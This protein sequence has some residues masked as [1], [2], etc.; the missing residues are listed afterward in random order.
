MTNDVN[1]SRELAEESSKARHEG[2][3]E[4]KEAGAGADDAASS[5]ATIM[6]EVQ[7]GVPQVTYIAAG[8]VAYMVFLAIFH[9]SLLTAVP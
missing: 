2:P 1:V 9:P 5:T 6:V 8:F 3:Q 4:G 7:Y